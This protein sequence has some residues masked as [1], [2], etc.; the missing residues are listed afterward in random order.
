MGNNVAGIDVQVY[1]GIENVERAVGVN[2]ENPVIPVLLVVGGSLY[3]GYM[4]PT[5]TL[6]DSHQFVCT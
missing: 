6:M 4:P 1:G 2:P 5:S 3:F